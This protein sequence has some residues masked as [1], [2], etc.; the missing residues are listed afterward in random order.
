MKKIFLE[1]KF[2][3]KIFCGSYRLA[4]FSRPQYHIP[5]R[6]VKFWI[7]SIRFEGVAKKDRQTDSPLLIIETSK[8]VDR[9][10]HVI[11]DLVETISHFL[12]IFSST[13]ISQK[14][15]K[16]ILGYIYSNTKSSSKL[17][18]VQPLNQAPQSWQNLAID[19]IRCGV[20]SGWCRVGSPSAI[21]E[22]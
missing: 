11:F 10:A 8:P 16:T 6:S 18:F 12:P 7:I 22:S 15:S 17:I 9:V 19:Y 4:D 14:V 2:F 21:K 1:S 13:A 20:S 5:W 3:E